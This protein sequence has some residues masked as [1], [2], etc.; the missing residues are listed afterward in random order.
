[1]STFF[2]ASR[3]TSGKLSRE[4]HSRRVNNT[5]SRMPLSTSCVLTPSTA[6]EIPLP[7]LFLAMKPP[8][9]GIPLPTSF[10]PTHIVASKMI[11]SDVFVHPI[12]DVL[13]HRKFLFIC[14]FLK[15]VIFN[16]FSLKYFAQIS[17]LFLLNNDIRIGQIF[18]RR[19]GLN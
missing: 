3:P 17:S 8:A 7:M 19:F 4:R 10:L 15:H 6:S 14:I 9:L 11:S 1:M 5:A 13:L 2:A 12:A 16:L 18:F